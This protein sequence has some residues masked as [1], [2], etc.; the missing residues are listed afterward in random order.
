MREQH[1][2]ICDILAGY[3]W[4]SVLNSDTK[5]ARIDAE[6]GV[7]DYLR[8][9]VRAENLRGQG[10]PDLAQRFKKAAWVLTRAFALCPAHEEVRPLLDDIGFFNSI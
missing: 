4:R 8:D 10:E 5:T 6:T 1:G 7:L 9:P 2:V 3:G